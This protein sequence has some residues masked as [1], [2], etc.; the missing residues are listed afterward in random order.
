MTIN[1][2]TPQGAIKY[3]QNEIKSTN[4]MMKE[5]G[6]TA[7][8]KKEMRAYISRQE[9]QIEKIRMNLKHNTRSN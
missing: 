1:S 9:I 8:T 7:A 3:L 6:T 2:I 5:K 4:K